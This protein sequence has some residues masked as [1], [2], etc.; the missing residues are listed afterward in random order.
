MSH[1]RVTEE[2]MGKS[3]GSRIIRILAAQDAKEVLEKAN[4]LANKML[5]A[6]K[7]QTL[8]YSKK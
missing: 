4:E 1:C 6:T 2:I 5:H 7:T 8:E 3:F